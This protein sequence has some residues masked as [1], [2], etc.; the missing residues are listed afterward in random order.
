[1]PQNVPNLVCA[2]AGTIVLFLLW[3]NHN[4][5][6]QLESHE[7]AEEGLV[8]ELDSAKA[9]YVQIESDLSDG[10]VLSDQKVDT[11]THQKEEIRDEKNRVKSE[12]EECN[13]SLQTK[14]DEIDRYREQVNELTMDA[15]C[16]SE[17]ENNE[18]LS[19]QSKVLDEQVKSL[20]KQLSDALD[21][22]EALTSQS[23]QPDADVDDDS[24]EPKTE[25][26]A[27]QFIQSLVD[28][29]EPDSYVEPTVYDDTNA[30][31]SPTA[32][33]LEDGEAETASDDFDETYEEEEDDDTEEEPDTNIYDDENAEEDDRYT[34]E[35]NSDDDDGKV[36]LLTSIDIRPF[37]RTWR[38][39][40]CRRTR[41]WC[42]LETEQTLTTPSAIL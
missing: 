11:L 30:D 23:L 14:M 7:Q 20:T 4:L 28:N 24:I 33:E 39:W 22:I 41:K 12:L 42:L 9:R 15:K 35:S 29:D 38:R 6:F 27:K 40:K 16:K 26:D 21:Q 17:K 34:Y 19:E 2:V 32:D 3:T 13:R 10:K 8:G 1:M 5:Q 36:L 25:D 37:S 31:E 18:K